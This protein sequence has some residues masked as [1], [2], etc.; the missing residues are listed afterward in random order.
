MRGLTLAGTGHVVNLLKIRATDWNMREF[1]QMR[2]LLIADSVA[3]HLDVKAVVVNMSVNY[4][5]GNNMSIGFVL[6]TYTIHSSLFLCIYFTN[7]MDSTNVCLEL[8]VT[9]AIVWMGK[10]A[11]KMY[12]LIVDS[13]LFSCCRSLKVFFRVL[14][15]AKVLVIK[16]IW[17]FT[18]WFTRR[19]DLTNVGDLAAFLVS[20]PAVIDQGMKNLAR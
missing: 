20:K 8:F 11:T 1:T 18:T 13:Q 2:N 6:H 19:R 5:V 15:V 16:R 17:I 3:L 7:N 9:Y 12:C 10:F 4:I 14:F